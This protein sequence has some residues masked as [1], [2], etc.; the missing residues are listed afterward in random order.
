MHQM[1]FVEQRGGACV[2]MASRALARAARAA[3]DYQAVYSTLLRQASSPVILHWLGEMFDPQL[4]NYWSGNA[5]LE[6]AM[7]CVLSIITEHRTKVAGHQGLAAGC[8][9]GNQ[10]TPSL[11]GRR[12]AVYRR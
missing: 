8:G 5:D 9:I 6:Q 7:D 3:D 11:A 10:D 1:E 4:A 12:A 2:L